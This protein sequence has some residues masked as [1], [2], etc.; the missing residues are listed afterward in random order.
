MCQGGT[1]KAASSRL[2][3]LVHNQLYQLGTT[4][5]AQARVYLQPVGTEVLHWGVL[6][7]PQEK[8]EKENEHAA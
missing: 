1:G 4:R 8:R 5:G 6:G 7:G 2:A 3:A